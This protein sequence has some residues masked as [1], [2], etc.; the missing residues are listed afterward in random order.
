MLLFSLHYIFRMAYNKWCDEFDFW[1]WY[2][3]FFRVFIIFVLGSLNTR[4]LVYEFYGIET[5]IW[6]HKSDSLCSKSLIVISLSHHIFLFEIYNITTIE[7]RFYWHQF[8]RLAIIFYNIILVDTRIYI[9]INAGHVV[10][11]YYF[12]NLSV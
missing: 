1:T 3:R 7:N 12:K 6:I 10:P 8:T 5:K 11:N 9:R 2:V 4:I